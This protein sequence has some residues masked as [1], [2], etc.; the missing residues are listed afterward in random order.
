MGRRKRNKLGWGEPKNKRKYWKVKENRG[1]VNTKLNSWGRRCQW[2]QDI[3]QAASDEMIQL[4]VK[5]EW[6]CRTEVHAWEVFPAYIW[7]LWS[8]CAGAVHRQELERDQHHLAILLLSGK[9]PKQAVKAAEAG[10]QL[11]VQ[12]CCVLHWH[13]CHMC[14]ICWKLWQQQGSFL[15]LPWSFASP[16]TS[17]WL[18]SQSTWTLHNFLL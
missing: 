7:S 4:R 14:Q 12:S 17:N 1:E 18:Q 10:Q 2:T 16:S 15:A 9:L 13:S 6:H 11:V 5:M 3:G 8:G